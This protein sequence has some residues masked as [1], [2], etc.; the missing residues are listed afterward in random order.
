MIYVTVGTMCFQYSI[1]WR[2]TRAKK[3]NCAVQ[4]IFL[5]RQMEVSSCIV[6]RKTSIL[7]QFM[8]CSF[9]RYEFKRSVGKKRKYFQKLRDT[10]KASRRPCCITKFLDVPHISWNFNSPKSQKR[11]P[12]NQCRTKVEFFTT[13]FMN[14]VVLRNMTPYTLIDKCLPSEGLCTFIIGLLSWWWG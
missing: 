5:F 11:F 3:I 9:H 14:I 8:C 1:S 12:T 7:L 4:F 13:M 2:T 10:P 6:I